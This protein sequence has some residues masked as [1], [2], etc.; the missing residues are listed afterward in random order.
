MYS[1]ILKKIIYPFVE[2]RYPSL[3]QTMDKLSILE[4]TQWRDPLEI[5]RFQQK[6][7]R[8]ILLHAYNNVPY[9]HNLF[10]KTNLKPST[11]AFSD[12]QKFPILTKEDIR[13]NLEDLK[14]KN[15]TEHQ[16]IPSATG[17]S[18]GEPMKF[19]ID[20]EWEAWNGA[21][22]YR[23]WGWAGYH[24]GDKMT[25]VWSSPYDVSLQQKLKNKLYNLLQRIIYLDALNLTEENLNNYVKTLNKYKPKIVNAY[26]S[27]IYLMAEYLKKNNITTIRPEAILTSCE[28]LIDNQRAVIE[29]AF[30]C[31]VFD[32]YSGRETTFH[33]GEC[34]E[35]SGYHMAI[36]NAVVEFIKNNE[37][38]SPGESGKIIITDLSNYAMPFI[39]YEIGDL[40]TPS[41]EHCPCGRNL[42]LIKQIQGRIRDIVTTQNGHYITGAFFSTLFY[43]DKG[44]TKGVKQFQFIQKTKN[45]AILKIVKGNDFSQT[46][47]EKIIKKIREKCENMDIEIIFVDSIPL[48]KSGKYRSTIS[49][50]GLD[51]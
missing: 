33:A 44:N 4:K 16:M 18:T 5:Q 50:V 48:T 3:K 12:L 11:V 10:K 51:L 35:H 39:R 2:I 9:Y 41:D 27:A 1:S 42:P 8:A 15:Y 29:E 47:L 30:G 36:E 37:H 46:E 21:A 28:T 19:Y 22:A 17:G 34:P 40:G 20:R 31:E 14:A 32:Y 24:I 43:D 26:A 45:H 25:Y 49:E 6:R 38:V 23:E 7:L 13:K